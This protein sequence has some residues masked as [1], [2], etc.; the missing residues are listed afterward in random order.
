MCHSND[1]ADRCSSPAFVIYYQ[2]TCYPA[3]FPL[4]N[5]CSDCGWTPCRPL[6][7]L[8]KCQ[9]QQRQLWDSC[10]CSW[11][12]PIRTFILLWLGGHRNHPPIPRHRLPC[13]LSLGCLRRHPQVLYKGCYGT[14]CSSYIFWLYWGWCQELDWACNKTHLD[15]DPFQPNT[16]VGG[17]Q[18][19]GGCGSRVWNLSGGR[20]HL[21]VSIYSEP[22]KARCRYCCALCDK[23]H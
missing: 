18:G 20:Q 12:C 15:W 1:H 23:I 7:V 9:S 3:D 22:S 16:L 10:S 8:P 6:R 2:L 17:H 5:I 11:G 21:P 19:R 13:D 4:Y 14:W